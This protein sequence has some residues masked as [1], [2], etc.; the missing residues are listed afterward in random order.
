M[1]N[2]G[3]F[4]C[5]N[6]TPKTVVWALLTALFGYSESVLPNGILKKNKKMACWLLER[7][8]F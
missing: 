8:L 4:Q 6:D 1:L 3:L 2:K 7:S 5:Q